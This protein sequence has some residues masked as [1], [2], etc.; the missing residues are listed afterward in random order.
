[1]KDSRQWLSMSWLDRYSTKT[2]L[3]T[4]KG[5]SGDRVTARVST[6]AEVIAD[7]EFH[8]EQKCA[9]A[10]GRGARLGERIHGVP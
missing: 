10:L 4:T 3:I 2:F 5:D 6:Y 8:P 1:M 7:Y 9:D